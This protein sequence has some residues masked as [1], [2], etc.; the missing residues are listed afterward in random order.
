MLKL[1]L[2]GK[3]KRGRL[4]RRFIDMVREDMV[5]VTEEDTEDMKRWKQ[6]IPCGNA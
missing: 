5:G 4:K 6:W 1:E 3:M 2:S